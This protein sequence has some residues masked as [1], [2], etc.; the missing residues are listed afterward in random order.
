MIFQKLP[1]NSDLQCSIIGDFS[2]SSFYAAGLPQQHHHRP[3]GLVTSLLPHPEAG[4]ARGQ[5]GNRFPGVRSSS[6]ARKGLWHLR[7]FADLIKASVFLSFAVFILLASSATFVM[8]TAFFCFLL[9]V[10]AYAQCF[11]FA[12]FRLTR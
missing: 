12:L 4:L 7:I 3:R 10:L 1:W 11:S 9:A 6:E 5:A 8:S 2:D